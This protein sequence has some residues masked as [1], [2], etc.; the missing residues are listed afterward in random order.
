M[1]TLT[2]PPT[3]PDTNDPTTFDARADAHIAWQATNVT[4][5]NAFQAALT[6]IAAGTAFAIPYTFSTTTTDSDPGAGILRLDNATQNTAT[7]IRADLLG[8][9]GSTWTDVLATFDD[10]TSTIKGQITLVKLGDA[11]KWLAFNVTALASPSGYKNISVAN[12]AS[13]AA[14]PFAD[15]DAIALQF[16]RTGD[17]GEIGSSGT[18]P[19][20]IRS[21]RT[22]NTI[23]AAGD[24]YTLI[25]ITSGTFTQTFTAAATLGSG[26]Y[27]Y[28]KN[29][30]TG[31]ITLDPDASELIDGLTSYVMYP[32]ECRLI[33]CTGTAFTSVVI[34]PFK[35]T[36]LT[37]LNP[38][39]TPPGYQQFGGLLHGGGGGGGKGAAGFY[40]GG[41]GGGC[42]TPFSLT[43]AAMGASQIITIGA[44][45]I[46]TTTNGAGGD[47]GTSSIGT[48]VYAYGGGGGGGNGA[49]DAYG[50]GG[51][52]CFSVGITGTGSANARGGKPYITDSSN[53][54]SMC[55]VYG[56]ARGQGSTDN[57]GDRDSVYGG[58]GGGS[59]ATANLA[60]SSLYGG[61]GGGGVSA[62]NAALN[63]GTSVFGGAGGAA[64]VAGNG[65]AGTVPAGGG[66]ATHTGTNSGAGG[67]GKCE[68]WGIV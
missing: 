27:C 62:A 57:A 45:G 15:T 10:S 64:S 56:G 31:D 65:T 50:G 68:I 19:S 35:R 14:S 53:G 2:A 43:S 55:G 36:I 25:D 23:L 49:A 30:G 32:G 8:S 63:P 16:T 38:F 67:A 13:S 59:S 44:G 29:S 54:Q 6:S 26:W 61:A 60:G 7:T 46:A 4:E 37:T 47:G 18:S 40:T 51:G 22:S 28:I 33:Q 52:G 17:K 9:D 24:N 66:G 39:T 5:M 20:V 3:A 1:T 58:G 42:C 21:A 12:V 41:G 11:T 48:L 34:T